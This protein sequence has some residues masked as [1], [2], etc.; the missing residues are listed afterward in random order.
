VVMDQE[1]LILLMC[2]QE[3]FL[4]LVAVRLLMQAAQMIQLVILILPL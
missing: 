2:A 1:A 4:L 3:Q